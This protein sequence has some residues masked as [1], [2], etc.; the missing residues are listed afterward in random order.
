MASSV[1]PFSQATLGGITVATST[2]TSVTAFDSNNS[3]QVAVS[4]LGTDAVHV[5]FGGSTKTATAADYIVFGGSQV[6]L[7]KDR[8]ATHVALIAT[9]ATPSIHVIA[10]KGA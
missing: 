6:I 3:S 8:E 5:S 10:G 7:S 4:N 9:A 1:Q 2:S